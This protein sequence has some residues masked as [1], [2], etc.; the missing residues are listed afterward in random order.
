[1]LQEE[2]RL[3]RLRCERGTEEDEA[4]GRVWVCS[5]F[6]ISIFSC[7]NVPANVCFLIDEAKLRGGAADTKDMAGHSS[8]TGVLCSTALLQYQDLE[9]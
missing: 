9:K 4:A 3:D 6:S 1:M 8:H 5:V 7:D 2:D